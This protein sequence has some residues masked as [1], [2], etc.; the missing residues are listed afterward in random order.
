MYHRSIIITINIIIIILS[1]GSIAHFGY[2][3]AGMGGEVT[4]HWEQEI[5]QFIRGTASN[6]I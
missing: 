2:Y 3:E 4:R 5:K 6:R 1:T